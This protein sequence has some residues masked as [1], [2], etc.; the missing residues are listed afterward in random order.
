MVYV[1][2]AVVAD[3]IGLHHVVALRKDADSSRDE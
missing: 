3:D 2:V 1:V